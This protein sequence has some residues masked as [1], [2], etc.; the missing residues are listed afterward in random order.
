MKPL[1]ILRFA[2]RAVTAYPLRTALMLLAMAIGVAAVVMLTA[3][4]DGARQ[5]VVNEFNALGSNL[6][7]VLPGRSETRGVN[8]GSF[9]T[10][11]PRDL[12]N[13]DAEAVRRV[14]G[15][16]RAA[17]LA[18]G[19]SEVSFGGKLRETMVLGTSAD[20][21][22]LRRFQMAQGSFLP[23][24]AGQDNAA[25]VVLGSKLRSELF[26]SAPAV[27]RMLRVGDRRYRVQGVL[28][29]TGNAM[30]LAIDEMAFIPTEQAFALFNTSTL[31]RIFIETRDRASI[32]ATR[33]RVVSLLK[34][35]H[36][37]EEDFNTI[38]QDAVL[39]TFDKILGAI[40][41]GVA[42]IA[43]ISLGVAGILV[44]N[45]MLVSVTQRTA[46][47]GLLKALG[48]SSQHIRSAFISEAVLLSLG[49]GV[50]GLVLG[51]LGAWALRIAYPEL[52]AW[53]PNWAVLAGLGTALLTGI[54][55]GWL[56][57]RR[58]AQLDPVDALGRR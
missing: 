20:Y 6:L 26:G 1:D 42:G 56:P 25:V 18:V 7:I 24:S 5:Y 17:P 11:T 34:A 14:P 40:T 45:V 46:E 16:V 28:A 9:F 49:G 48:A 51:Q 2:L 32:E 52:P 30:G 36:D 37:G 31:F 29:P 38:T 12:S 3:L 58:A 50:V 53:P 44:M 21:L 39:G 19:T 10:E 4:G 57:A 41:L 43:A 54:L 33:T 23:A 47:I 15:V 22:P 27:G 35:R 55:F 8:P 13:A